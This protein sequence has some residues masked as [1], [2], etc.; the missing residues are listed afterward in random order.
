MHKILP[1]LLFIFSI[2]VVAQIGIGTT[3]PEAELDVKSQNAGILFPRIALTQNDLAAP[4][5]DPNTG[6][7]SV[8]NTTLIYNTSTTT[9]TTAVSP[10]I[11]SWFFGYWIKVSTSTPT[12]ADWYNLNSSTSPNSLANN[13]FTNGQ[14]GIGTGANT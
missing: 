11:Y 1:T 3:E 2:S 6:T 7:S 9:G 13:I 5:I 4:V 12:N 14:V 10:G 8:I